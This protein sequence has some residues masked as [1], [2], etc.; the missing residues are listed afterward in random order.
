MLIK[1]RNIILIYLLLLSSLTGFSQNPVLPEEGALYIADPEP[2]VFNGRVYVYGSKDIDGPGWCSDQYH[3]VSSA[4]LINWTDHGISF[5]LSDV[6]AAYMDPD[7]NRLWAPDLVK[8]PV[9]GKYYL[10]FC[11]NHTRP[12]REKIMVAES[13]SP[14][15]PFKNARPVTIEGQPIV[16]ID[17]AVMVDDD[18]KAY[19]SWPFKMAQLD[20]ED[21]SKII[22]KTL[23]DVEQWMPLYDTP[24]EGPSL[25]KRGN[26]YYYI[27]IQNNGPRYLPDST[28]NAKPTKMA[29]LTSKHPLGPYEYKGTIIENTNYPGAINIHGSLLDFNNQWYVFY[30]LPVT[31]KK[32]VR[33]M[34]IE[35]VT[36]DSA[37]RILP[38]LISS[39]G[40]K[41]AFVAGD[42]IRA[43]GAV[44]YSNTSDV[45]CVSA[46]AAKAKLVFS[47]DS[48]FA[49]YRYVDFT[50]NKPKEMMLSVST[51]GPGCVLE[52]RVDKPNGPLVA[53]LPIPDT[54][55]HWQKLKANASS[56]IEGKKTVF[57]ILRNRNGKQVS[58]EWMLFL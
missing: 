16:A 38:V 20:P 18:G 3:V 24:F 40:V 11:F 44:V 2:K 26:T 36:F 8:H 17:P 23:V 9:N 51:N 29:Y 14:T 4:D 13:D 56:D 34:C 1:N 28:V 42:T 43:A 50:K 31:D 7:Y 54:K 58:F 32:L 12:R 5:R 39:S 46:P 22:S 35:P 30:H 37:G 47:A 19:I 15:G 41:D 55:G 25:R 53:S 45:K 10:F 49:G 6:P 33:R 48:A 52:L 27:Y 57:V 21:Y